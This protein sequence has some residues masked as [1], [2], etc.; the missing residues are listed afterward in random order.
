MLGELAGLL[1]FLLL[2][3]R[4]GRR[5]RMFGPIFL[6]QTT[7]TWKNV[8]KKLNTT[9]AIGEQ[10]EKPTLEQFEKKDKELQN[11]TA[12]TTAQIANTTSDSKL[13][14]AQRILAQKGLIR[15]NFEGR[16]SGLMNKIYDAVEKSVRQQPQ[17][18]KMYPENLTPPMP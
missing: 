8:S 13:K 3:A 16:V 14:E 2:M 4:H 6:K 1:L 7:T 5:K 12:L 11:Q 15:A 10:M 17:P 9:N 18:G